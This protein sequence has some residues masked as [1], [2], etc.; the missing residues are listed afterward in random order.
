MQSCRPYKHIQARQASI[1]RS[2]HHDQATEVALQLL[3]IVVPD[4]QSLH[5][6]PAI[7]TGLVLERVMAAVT[8]TQVE[9]H[10]G[11]LPLTYGPVGCLVLHVT[12]SVVLA[13]ALIREE[14]YSADTSARSW[15]APYA[16]LSISA[17]QSCPTLLYPHCTAGKATG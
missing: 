15:E 5:L 12:V 6:L 9:A 17:G 14:M 3:L 13:V 16:V 8:D 7:A 4:G 10:R 11:F 1:G 2:P